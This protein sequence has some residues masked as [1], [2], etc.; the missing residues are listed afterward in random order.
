MVIHFYIP[1]LADKIN[2]KVCEVCGD[3]LFC[4]KKKLKPSS[5]ANPA[6]P[7]NLFDKKEKRKEKKKGK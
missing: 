4:D 1:D 5:D 2:Q 3:L 6:E 7:D